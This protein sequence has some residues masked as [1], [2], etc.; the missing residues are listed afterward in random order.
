MIK[1]NIDQKEI[2]KFEIIAR[3]WWDPCSEFKPLHDINP[4]R[5][6]Y[7]T[8]RTN[9]RGKRVLDVGCG[10]GILSEALCE[11]EAKV[12]G[13]D[14]GAAPIS[15][16]KLHQVE[17]GYDID[18]MQLTIEAL[19]NQHP[20]PYDVITCLEM[21]E[22][23]PDPDSIIQTCSHLLKPSGDLFL[24]TINRNPKSY[25]FMVLGAEYLLRLLPKGTHSYSKF[26]TPAE[27]GESIRTHNLNLND[28]T[29]MTY[30]P[31]TKR[32]KLSRDVDVNYIVHAK[33]PS[34]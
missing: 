22:H 6:A 33:K 11:A 21:L 2:D 29:G 34:L 15:V 28:L 32:Y 25:L 10:G 5:L 30:N 31:I 23:V 7:I 20:E 3:R 16:A 19:A 17:S 8:E 13:I 1:D 12:T 14:A 27:V 24:S 18:Y 4:L 9:L 26:I